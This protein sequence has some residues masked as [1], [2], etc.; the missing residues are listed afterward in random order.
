MDIEGEDFAKLAVQ[1]RCPDENGGLNVADMMSETNSGMILNTI[2]VMGLAN[3]ESVLELG[4]GG[5]SHLEKLMERASGLKYMGLDISDLMDKVARKYN[6]LFCEN[7]IADFALYNGNQIPFGNNAFDKIFTVNTLYF[8]ETPAELMA[9]LH[10][11]LRPGGECLVTFVDKG[12]MEKL[13]FAENGFTLYDIARFR[14]L[15][16]MTEFSLSEVRT[17]TEEIIVSSGDSVERRYS[18]A[19][20]LKE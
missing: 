5:A 14:D 19:R 7:G 20:L 6:H 12:F 16:D 17:F 3:G 15:A 4:H 8:W 13:P 9:E 18:V 1:L 2:R 11:V 10:R